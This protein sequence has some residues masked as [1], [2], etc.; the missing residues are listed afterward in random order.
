MSWPKNPKYNNTTAITA[1]SFKPASGSSCATKKLWQKRNVAFT[2]MWNTLW[3]WLKKP[4]FYPKRLQKLAVGSETHPLEPC[5]RIPGVVK[6]SFWALGYLTAGSINTIYFQ[7]LAWYFI[8]VCDL[9]QFSDYFTS[10]INPI[11]FG[12]CRMAGFVW[13]DFT[14]N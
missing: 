10:H 6:V 4:H 8:G 5:L 7:V 11:I 9:C 12:G 3:L 13:D 14:W 1:I 2:K